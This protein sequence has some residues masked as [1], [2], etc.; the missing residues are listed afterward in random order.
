MRNILEFLYNYWPLII[1][2]VLILVLI[3]LVL[4]FC[5]MLGIE[6]WKMLLSGEWT[7]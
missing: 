3:M 6:A 4:P 5:I 7:L 1:A 2:A